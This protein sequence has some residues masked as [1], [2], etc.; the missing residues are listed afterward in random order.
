MRR[1][2]TNDTPAELT[3]LGNT[4]SGT[5][6]ATSN[7]F[8]CA[9]GKTYACLVQLA[10]RE[11]DGTSAF[12]LRQVLI[13]NVGGTVSLEGSAQTVGVDINPAGWPGP[14]FAAD[15]TNKS[16]QILVTGAASTNIRWCATIHAQEV[17]Y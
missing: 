8:I 14:S 13:K 9:S 6:E 2:T 11:D 16:L 17:G 5:S 12:F 3:I 1:A 10:A 7:R 15:D 4:P